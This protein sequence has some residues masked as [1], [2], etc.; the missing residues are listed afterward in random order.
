MKT[1]K[2]PFTC[3]KGDFETH[4]KEL[5]RVQ[6]SIYHVAYNRAS[7]G[8]CEIEIRSICRTLFPE[9]D[10]WVVQSVIKKGMGQFKADW[11]LAKKQNR[12]FSGK[13]IFGGGRNHF[14]DV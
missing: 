9:I 13:R 10:S 3:F 12:E 8:L 14:S 2:I 1:L 6:T 7:E 5:Q 4:L 11:E